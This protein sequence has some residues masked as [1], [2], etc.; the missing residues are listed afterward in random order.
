MFNICKT[1][2]LYNFNEATAYSHLSKLSSDSRAAIL[3]LSSL[4]V[5]FMNTL[6]WMSVTAV[7]QETVRLMSFLKQF[8]SLN[9][10]KWKWVEVA[11][12]FCDSLLNYWALDQLKRQLSADMQSQGPSG[13]I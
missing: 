12:A 3:A 6:F 4:T 9:N 7:L 10:L 13:L 8:F 2:S 11:L 5:Y 1:K